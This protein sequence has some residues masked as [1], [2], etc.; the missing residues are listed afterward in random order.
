MGH[1]TFLSPA[2]YKVTNLFKNTNLKIAFRAT[3]IIFQQLS[4]IPEVN[5]PPG[6]YRI[7]C[8]TCNKAYVGQSGRS[9]YTRHKEHIRYIRGNYPTSAYATHILHNRHAYGPA[10][11]TLRLLKQFPKGTKMDIW[12]SMYIHAYKK[13]KHA[14]TGTTGSRSQLAMRPGTRTT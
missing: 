6:I 10:E 7:N 11:T 1:F 12:E 9:V 8:N 2:I 14:N 5:N 3:N 13:T 4:Q